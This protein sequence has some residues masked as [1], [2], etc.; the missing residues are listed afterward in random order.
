MSKLENMYNEKVMDHFMHPRNMGKMDD[1]TH[2]AQVGNPVCGDVMELYL[3]VENGK[4][5]KASFLA[6]GCGAAIA[7]SSALTEM[8][9]GKTIEEAKKI[10]NLEVAEYLGGLPKEKLHCSV[11]ARQAVSKALDK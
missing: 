1:F 7:G 9:I 2:K 6:F 5:K 11:L 10:K 8:L 4:I 3:K